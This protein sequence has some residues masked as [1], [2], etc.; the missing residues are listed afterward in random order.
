MGQDF[1]KGLDGV[2]RE[3]F[4]VPFELRH[5][6]NMGWIAGARPALPPCSDSSSGI[7]RAV[8][9]PRLAIVLDHNPL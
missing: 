1:A 2:A 9:V 3:T 7:A 4:D 6:A 8:S 5:N